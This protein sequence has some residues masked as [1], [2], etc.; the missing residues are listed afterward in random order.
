VAAA[1]LLPV[2][3]IIARA[4]TPAG[5]NLNAN[6]MSVDLAEETILAF[7]AYS[8]LLLGKTKCE[9][10]FVLLANKGL[11][12]LLL[13]KLSGSCWNYPIMQQGLL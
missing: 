7:Y 11:F 2:S 9:K 3:G 8:A 6:D 1:P 12:G 13:S 5:H 10:Q 4:R